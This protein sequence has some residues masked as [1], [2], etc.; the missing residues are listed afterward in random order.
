MSHV[1]NAFG[2]GLGLSASLARRASI[3]RHRGRLVRNSCA[4][5]SRA[6]IS[7]DCQV[8]A[9]VLLAR[10]G[11][12]GTIAAIRDLA[13]DQIPVA[14]LAESLLECGRWSNYV[15][16]TIPTGPQADPK[17]LLASLEKLTEEGTGP[18]APV[19][20]PSCDTSAWTYAAYADKLSPHFCLYAPP[21]ETMDRILDKGRFETAC[22]DAGVPV[23]KSWMVWNEAAIAQI[24]DTLL[25]PLIIKPRTHVRRRRNDKGEVV[26]NHDQLVRALRRI[27][28]SERFFDA[29]CDH[30]NSQEFFLQQFVDVH[31]KGVLSVTGF[32]DRSGTHFV[33]GAAQDTAA[34]RTGGGGCLLRINAARPRACRADGAPVPQAWL[35]RCV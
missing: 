19:L 32:M 11:Y 13:Q 4:N 20:L 27:G 7:E 35:F 26:A 33:A 1:S 31:P 2:A 16:A 9:P 14:V 30:A 17:A 29:D 8:A 5:G 21:L 28:R 6:S 23:L 24:A 15:S 18:V 3:N 34:L 25:F 22:A 10:P 12:G